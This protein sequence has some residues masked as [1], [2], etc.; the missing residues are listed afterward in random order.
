M[1]GREGQVAADHHHCRLAS[2]RTQDDAA[3]NFN[4]S[5]CASIPTGCFKTGIP[6]V[7]MLAGTTQ[8]KPRQGLAQTGVQ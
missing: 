1:P 3:Q 4:S 7:L 2:A 6:A 8:H 5:R